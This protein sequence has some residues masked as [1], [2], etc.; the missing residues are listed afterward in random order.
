MEARK[1]LEEQAQPWNL[2]FLPSSCGKNV[3]AE[4]SQK[5]KMCDRQPEK[6]GAKDTAVQTLPRLSDASAL[7]E[8]FGLRRLQRRFSVLQGAVSTV[9]RR[10]GPGK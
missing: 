2:P 1:Y 10:A 7:R 5:E 4:L 6:S 3:V 8:A 9:N